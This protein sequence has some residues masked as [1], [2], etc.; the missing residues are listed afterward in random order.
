VAKVRRFEVLPQK[1]LD[2]LVADVEQFELHDALR[3]KGRL[4]LACC[5]A[6]A[7]L[8]LPGS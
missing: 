2:L 6:V 8:Q 4:L 3:S 7:H 1:R 5:L